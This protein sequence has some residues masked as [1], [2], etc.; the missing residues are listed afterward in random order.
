MYS[1]KYNSHKKYYYIASI[2]AILFLIFLIIYHFFNWTF[3]GLGNDCGF[4][5]LFHCYCPGCGGT[6]A[7]DSFLHGKILTSVLYHPAILITFILFMAY[8]LPATYT[9]LIKKD[10]LLYYKFHSFTL[11][12]LLASIVLHF[13]IRNILLIFFHIDYI[14]DCISYYL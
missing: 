8:Y 3:Y 13:V 7:L 14:Q 5:T 1:K 12:F 4:K 6:R 10:G 11:W 9:F 2:L